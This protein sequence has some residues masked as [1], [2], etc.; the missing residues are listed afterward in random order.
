MRKEWKELHGEEGK[1]FKEAE[2]HVHEAS[3]HDIHVGTKSLLVEKLV[4]RW[5]GPAHTGLIRL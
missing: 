5:A 1:H 4:D 2:Q 3:E